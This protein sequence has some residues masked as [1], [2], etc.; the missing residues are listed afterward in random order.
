MKFPVWLLLM[1]R[2]GM[3][4]TI[5]EAVAVFPV[6]PLVEVT[7]PVVLTL[8]PPV[9][10]VTLTTKGQI[11]LAATV[12]P[13]RLTLP[14][15][16][17]AV[18]VPPPQEPVSPFGVATTNPLGK[19][20]VTATPVRAAA[21]LELVLLNVRLVLLPARILAAPNAFAIEGGPRLVMLAVTVALSTT[22]SACPA[23][24]AV[25]V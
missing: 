12:P 5:T 3:P 17:V 21:A 2:S 15:P 11:P 20:S 8:F 7:A 14:E 25:A 24:L 13:V 10:P 1:V 9:V 16:A 23:P 4:T 22:A 18:M 6:P 19:R